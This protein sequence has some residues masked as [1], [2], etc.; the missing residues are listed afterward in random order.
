MEGHTVTTAGEE[1]A[2][3]FCCLCCDPHNVSLVPSGLQMCSD[4]LLCPL[5]SPKCDNILYSNYK[6]HVFKYMEIANTYAKQTQHT[7]ILHV[8]LV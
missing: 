2:S 3:W 6:F 1:C 4:R 5:P 7:K 8:Y